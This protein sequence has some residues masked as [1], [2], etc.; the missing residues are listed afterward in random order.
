MRRE[1]VGANNALIGAA[2][3]DVDL[4]ALGII[5]RIHDVDRGVSALTGR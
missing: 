1:L 3:A 4:E 2:H 5:A